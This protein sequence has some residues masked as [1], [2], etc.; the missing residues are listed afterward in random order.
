MTATAAADGEHAPRSAASRR[1]LAALAGLACIGFLALGQWQLARRDWKLA[2]IERV[3]QRIRAP[4]VAAPGVAEWPQV[5][6]ARDEYRRVAV[7][8]RFLHDRRALVQATTVLGAGHWL[9]TP[10]R[11]ADSS[12]VLV[13]RG[14]V[15][16]DQATPPTP[17]AGPSR[18][19]A[20]AAEP[21]T[22][23]GLMRMPEPG[24][25]FLRR[26]DP[27]ADRWYSRDVA[28]IAR[29]R[30]LGPVAPYFIDA[31]AAPGAAPDNDGTGLPVGGLT[32]TSFSNHHLVYAITWF[33]LAAMAASAAVFAL[34]GTG[35]ASAAARGR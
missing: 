3:E 20:S 25:G 15:A 16:P 6:A 19:A 1:V 11:A 21:V 5:S 24:G 27:A 14:F 18:P 9:I 33:A 10:L 2:L 35:G 22:V 30:G 28:A 26:N 12:I 7:T 31:D 34:R 8:G 23:Q 32:V 4:A 29:A 17:P 13:N